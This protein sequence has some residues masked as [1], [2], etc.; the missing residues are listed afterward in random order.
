M[1]SN[2]EEN[3]RCSLREGGKNIKSNIT[4]AN[5]N[6]NIGTNACGDGSAIVQTRCR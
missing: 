3:T 5:V 2:K 4:C 1:W 6:A